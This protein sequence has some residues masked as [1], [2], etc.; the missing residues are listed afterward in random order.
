MKDCCREML[1]AGQAL[2]H[3]VKANPPWFFYAAGIGFLL[4]TIFQPLECWIHPIWDIFRNPEYFGPAIGAAFTIGVLLQ[5]AIAQEKTVEAQNKAVE[6]QNKA[7]EAQK[8]QIE[9]QAKTQNRSHDN[10]RFA[11]AVEQIGAITSAGNPNIEVRLGGL[12]ILEELSKIKREDGTLPYYDQVFSILAAYAVKNAVPGVEL[13][14]SGEPKDDLPVPLPYPRVDVHAA[15]GL[16]GRRRKVQEDFRVPLQGIDLRYCHLSGSQLEDENLWRANLQG[17]DLAYASLQRSI[18]EEANL[19]YAILFNAELQDVNL[20]RARLR[21]AYLRCANLQN[22][23]LEGADLQD[24][25]IQDTYLEGVN[26]RGARLK[27]A[28]LRHAYLVRAKLYEEQLKEAF[29]D[30]GTIFPSYILG[31]GEQTRKRL[32]DEGY[33]FH[34]DDEDKPADKPEEDKPA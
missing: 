30:E 22:A 8:L 10:D 1:A 15:W 32:K 21:K 5:R 25:D 31:G 13:L 11:K 17:A 16:I 7:V 2:W 12:Y 9:V 28:D 14:E 6:A 18:F 26:L 19:Q 20:R 3:W 4:P 34:P 33:T 29:V 27:N 23:I 24:A